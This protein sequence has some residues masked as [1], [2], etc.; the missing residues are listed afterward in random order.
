MP[1]SF[2]WDDTEEIGI[3]LSEKHPKTDPLTVRFTDLLKLVTELPGFSGDAKGSN[4]GKLEAIQ[5]AWHE[6]YQERTH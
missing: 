2:G 1:Q 5:M 4:E 6:E 3:Q